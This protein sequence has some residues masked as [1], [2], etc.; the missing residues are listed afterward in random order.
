MGIG[1][2]QEGCPGAKAPSK[3]SGAMVW[4]G[5]AKAAENSP[6]AKGTLLPYGASPGW[7]TEQGTEMQ[8][9]N[10]SLERFVEQK[11]VTSQNNPSLSAGNS[12]QG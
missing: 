12:F 2:S 8:R 11:G 10:T 4:G 1:R 6:G 3:I 9:Q 7:G 5:A